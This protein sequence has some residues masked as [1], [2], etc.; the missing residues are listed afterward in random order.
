MQQETL[1][2]S[3]QPETINQEAQAAEHL[4]LTNL[5]EPVDAS[6]K[7]NTVDAP[8]AGLETTYNLNISGIKFVT[9]VVGT[10]EGKALLQ[11]MNSPF[12]LQ[13]VVEA[14]Y[15]KELTERLKNE[16]GN[17]STSGAEV[18][19]LPKTGSKNSRR[20]ER[21]KAKLLAE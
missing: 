2:V 1:A 11:V 6:D 8:Y 19:S 18:P 5:A 20:R 9:R 14:T 15:L 17:V 13:L 12:F 10:H 4:D 3:Q 21:R 16:I 7:S